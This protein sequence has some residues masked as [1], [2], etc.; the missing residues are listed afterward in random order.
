MPVAAASH[1][2]SESLRP[3]TRERWRHAEYQSSCPDRLSCPLAAARLEASGEIRGVVTLIAKCLVESL[4]NVRHFEATRRPYRHQ[5]RED[6]SR[7]RDL[8]LLPLSDPC[9]NAR[10]T[11]PQ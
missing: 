4:H 5:A 3:P 1:R 10:K 11:V 2:R 8:H 9:G 6:F 7:P